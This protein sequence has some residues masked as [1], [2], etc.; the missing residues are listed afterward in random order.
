MKRR[1]TSSKPDLRIKA[2][3][4]PIGVERK[5]AADID[6]MMK[7]MAK[8]YKRQTIQAL[9][10]GTVEKFAD[11]AP[12]EFFDAQRGNYASI[13]LKLSK[14]VQR[15]LLRRFTNARIEALVNQ[16]L[17]EA[18]KSNKDRLYSRIQAALG[19]SADELKATEGMQATR[20]ALIKE[21]TQWITKT[22]DET[23]EFFTANTLRAMT[24]G[25][26]LDTIMSQFD[27]MEETRRN[28]AKFVA[29]NQI[30]NY[31]SVMTKTRAQEVGVDEAYW[32]TEGDDLVRESHADRNG[33]KFKLSEGCY[34]SKDGL[35]LL[36]GV[37]YN[38][39]CDYDLIIPQD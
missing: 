19:V 1:L 23:L 38:C 13:F 18:D 31:N 5:F 28:H 3:R 15:K 33:K 37:D 12:S 11:A 21:T 35:H 7:A 8:Q 6:K 36:P 34:S 9:N 4:S 25:Q 22:R 32:R 2:P 20:N 29:R 10:K 16:R 27:E 14:A 39:R 30:N 17:T 26:G 24:L